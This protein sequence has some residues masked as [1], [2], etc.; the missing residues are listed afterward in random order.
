M[1]GHGDTF[2]TVLHRLMEHDLP[3]L[4]RQVRNFYDVGLTVLK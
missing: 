1:T 2:I 3:Q 4:C